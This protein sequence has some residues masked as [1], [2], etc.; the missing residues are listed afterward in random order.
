VRFVLQRAGTETPAPLSFGEIVLEPNRGGAMVRGQLVPLTPTEHSLLRVL[1]EAQGRVV[2]REQLVVRSRAQ[3]GALPLARSIEAHVRSLRRKLGDDPEAPR[4]VL[5]VRGF[6]YRLSPSTSAPAVDLVAATIQALGDPILVLDE[7]QRVKLMNPA[8]ER[9][10]GRSAAE[11][12][13]GL[14]CSALLQTTLVLYPQDQPRLV[15]INASKLPG[16]S[17]LL[18]QLRERERA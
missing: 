18:L 4:L 8:A 5:T 16:S 15:D 10:T 2:P 3:A 6:G 7:Q 9:L 12:I 14:R 11:S 1:I 17:G 13:N